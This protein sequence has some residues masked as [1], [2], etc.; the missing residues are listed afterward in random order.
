MTVE[1]LTPIALMCK[2]YAGD[3][4]RTQRLASSIEAYNSDSIPA[5]ISVPSSDMALFKNVIGKD[6]VNW[7]C[8]EDIIG[9]QPKRDGGRYRT[10]SGRLSQQVI[11][12]E[13]WRLGL[14][15]NYVCLDSDA[16]FIQDFHQHHFLN[17]T[18]KTPYTVLCQS[19]EFLQL[20]QNRGIDKVLQYFKKESAEGK[21]LF[22]R[23]GTDYDFCT[24]PVILSAKVW[25]D[26]YDRYLA[27]KDMDF[28]DAI[29]RFPNE[30]RWYGEA[31]LEYKS[32]P[33]M[34]IQPL[35]RVYLYDWH[36]ARLRRSGETPEKLKALF[37]GIVMQSNWEY[38]MDAGQQAS[39]KSL[40]S[41]AA[42]RV[43]RMLSRFR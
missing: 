8:D 27:P 10:W 7:L 23:I 35:F 20:S 28:W 19:K 34:P 33:L 3:V 41:R 29:E 22:N 32:I 18:T 21:A 6:R 11:K 16:Q 39:R 2:S 24:Q 15:S 30:L 9:A 4:K 25:Q 36:Y 40:M 13:F 12:A 1:R 31:L 42:R 26:L 5:Y 17:P 38:E 14:C 43:R 37:L